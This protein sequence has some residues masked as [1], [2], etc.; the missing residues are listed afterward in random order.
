MKFVPLSALL[1][2]PFLSLQGCKTTST[3]IDYN[4][5]VNF[6]QFTQ[7]SILTQEAKAE[8]D[9][10]TNDRIQ[11]AVVAQLSA[12]ALSQSMDATPLQVSYFATYEEKENTSSFSIGLGGSS[13]GGSSSTGIGLGTSFPM[14]ADTEIYTQITI[15]FNFEGK[16]VWRGVD[17]FTAD[18]DI[19]PIEKNEK[20]QKTIQEILSQYPP[21]S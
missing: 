11:Q 15:D 2:L 1:L 13:H 21:K 10:L 4:T 7:Y 8:T 3:N 5:E 12:K 18:P 16:L 9:T 14:G 20:I 6:S 17:G 19:T